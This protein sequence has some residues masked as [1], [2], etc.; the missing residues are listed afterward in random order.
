VLG[1]DDPTARAPGKGFHLKFAFND[2][3][4]FPVTL[5]KARRAASRSLPGRLVVANSSQAAS[6]QVPS[7]AHSLLLSAPQE[8][9]TSSSYAKKTLTLTVLES[10]DVSG[11]NPTEVGTLVLN[12][13]DFASTDAKTEELRKVIKASGAI[14]TVVGDPF[15]AFSIRCARLPPAWH[16]PSCPRALQRP[17]HIALTLAHLPASA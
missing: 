1:A 4:T 12:L 11:R 15:L 6:F 3:V 8:S 5:Y 13:A 2:T 7:R 9:E 14:T 16:P 10:A 17:P